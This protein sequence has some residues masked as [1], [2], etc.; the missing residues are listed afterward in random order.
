MRI[1]N[2]INYI[3]Y[4]LYYSSLVAT[5]VNFI[6]YTKYI[7]GCASGL[8]LIESNT[9]FISILF[10]IGLVLSI[11]RDVYIKQLYHSALNFGLFVSNIVVAIVFATS[12][13]QLDTAIKTSYYSKIILCS[14]VSWLVHELTIV[15]MAFTRM[16]SRSIVSGYKKI[17]LDEFST[18][19]T[20]DNWECSICST[21]DDSVEI[22]KLKTCDHIY[23]SDCLNRWINTNNI[24]PLCR[25]TIIVDR[26]VEED[27][28]LEQV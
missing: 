11:Y 21:G 4:F 28:Q 13:Q 9:T 10:F 22:V 7:F 2:F 3:Y 14:T 24:C 19:K 20:I 26:V 1:L 18:V 12:N 15:A 16:D 27:S 8:Y 6:L 25:K 5:W 17:N 23:H